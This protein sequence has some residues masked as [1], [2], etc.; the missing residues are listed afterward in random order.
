VV[1]RSIQ[2]SAFSNVSPLFLFLSALDATKV[3]GEWDLIGY[4]EEFVKSQHNRPT[5]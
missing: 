3:L 5:N 1:I 4:G 2:Q